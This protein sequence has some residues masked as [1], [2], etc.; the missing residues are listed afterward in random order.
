[1]LRNPVKQD[2]LSENGAFTWFIRVQRP[3]SSALDRLRQ[4]TTQIPEGYSVSTLLPW[5]AQAS[6]FSFTVIASIL[7]MRCPE[8]KELTGPEPAMWQLC[9]LTSIVCYLLINSN[10]AFKAYV[11]HRPNGAN[12]HLRR[13]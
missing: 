1:M 5:A 8:A 6:C 13:L 7:E 3:P 11:S 4:N 9:H 12:K 10:L 2:W